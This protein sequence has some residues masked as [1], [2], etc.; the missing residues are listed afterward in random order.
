MYDFKVLISAPYL[1]PY[2]DEFKEYFHRNSILPIIADV[3]ER[4]EED[5]LLNLLED[6]DGTIAGD[7]RYTLK[8]LERANNLKVISKWGT[9][10]D[11]FDRDAAKKKGIKI[12]NVPGAFNDP[13]SESVIGYML[14]FSRRLVF[15][16][17]E[18]RDG[19][20]MKQL[21]TTIGE[22]T[23]GIVGLG[24]IGK[25][26]IRK[27]SQFNTKLLG[28]D[29]IEIDQAFLKEYQVELVS[30][31]ELYENSD[32]ISLNC[33][34]NSTSMHLLNDNA[35]NKMNKSAV[36]I[37]C[38]R[39]PIID[40]NALAKAMKDKKI[41]G[42]A[43]DVFE[44]EPLPAESPLRYYKNIL[45]APHNSNS[46]PRAWKRVHLLSIRNLF[47]GLGISDT[48]LEQLT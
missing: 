29:I 1:I 20:W 19:K 22:S 38:A 33:D 37:N 11:S 35:F 43:L 36:V 4:L 45:L 31:D 24:E 2:F 47:R 23:V 8:V 15:M 6:I 18:M 28:N 14:A 26:I 10:I 42:A 48:E 9:G 13:V 32:F 25:T 12:F 3:C 17:K 27:L 34:L 39:G 46:S 41:A 40:N 5:E 7:D 44:Q 30:K 21:G 16:D